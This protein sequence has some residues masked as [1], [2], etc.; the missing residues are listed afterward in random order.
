MMDEKRAIPDDSFVATDACGKKGFGCEQLTGYFRLVDG[1]PLR[2]RSVESRC[3]HHN[4][5]RGA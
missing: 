1:S 3:T 5:S 4:G 2:G